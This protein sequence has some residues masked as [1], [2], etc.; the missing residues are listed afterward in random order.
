MKLPALIAAL[1]TALCCAQARAETV[2]LIS[3]PGL[4]DGGASWLATEFAA[5][6]AET[7][8]NV[9]YL[10]ADAPD[11][12]TQIAAARGHEQADLMVTRPPFMQ[13]AEHEKLVLPYQPQ[14]TAHIPNELKDDDG[15]YEAVANDYFGFT[16]DSAALPAPPANFAG[17]LAPALRGKIA[18]AAPDRDSDAEAA[19]LQMIHAFGGEDAA[20]AFLRQLHPVRAGGAP[21]SLIG[22][23]DLRTVMAAGAQG[24]ATSIFFPAG[25][26]GRRTTLA[27]PYYIALVRGGPDPAGAR[28]LLDFLLGKPA[29]LQVS[30]LAYAL[31]ARDDLRPGDAHFETSA[32]ALAGV[33]IWAPNWHKARKALDSE[34]S[35]WQAATGG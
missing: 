22:D 25:P 5:F 1:A 26:D 28:K 13:M 18:F 17:F 20:F 9:R 3:A 14:A 6:T 21:T 24:A 2:T 4:H 30:A 31:P 15:D 29:Q 12:V 10:Q 32:Q 27:L 35:R 11:V 19:M 23:G 33:V 7:G 16:Y 8:I 34:T